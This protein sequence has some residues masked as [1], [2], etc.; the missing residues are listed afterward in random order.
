MANAKIENRETTRVLRKE[1][2]RFAV[3][4]GEVVVQVTHGNVSLYGRVR[5]M[6]GHEAT[7]ESSMSAMLAAMRAQRG[8]HDVHAEWHIMA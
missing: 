6:K 2:S 1:M 8:I 3:D 4:C 5:A 7:F